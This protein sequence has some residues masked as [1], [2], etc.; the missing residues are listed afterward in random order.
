MDNFN[1]QT[2]NGAELD[3]VTMGSSNKSSRVA[4]NR[5]PDRQD[6]NPEMKVQKSRYEHLVGVEA[7]HVETAGGPCHQLGGGRPLN[8]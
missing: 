2:I 5:N 7:E 1:T 8:K 3:G 6:E 4:G